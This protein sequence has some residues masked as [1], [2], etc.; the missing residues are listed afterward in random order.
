M[1]TPEPAPPAIPAGTALL[2]LLAWL[3]PAFPIGGFS[4]SHGLE[5]A[6]DR[7]LVASAADLAGWIDHL[8]AHGSAAADA[9][10]LC[11]AWRAEA[12][13][14][15][16]LADAVI[17]LADAA[18]PTAELAL[19]SRA[20]GEA[21]LNA[22]QDGWP[23]PALDRYRAK[24]ARRDR[25]PAHAPA[26]GV[27][28]AA[29]GIGLAAAVAAYLQAFAAGLT[30]AGVKLIPLG[31]RAGLRVQASCEPAVLAAA[32]SAQTRPLTDL[33]TAAWVADWTSAAHETQYTRLFRS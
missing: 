8:L 13:G 1:P 4:Y 9:V 19:E 10:L 29:A 7:G 30:A 22:W 15:Q 2:R 6:V 18:R 23:G 31:Q 17:D 21:F 27:A 20:Q 14:D 11:H 25:P 24:L 28:A 32:A 33:A 12:T 16:A 26:V 5:T 3:S